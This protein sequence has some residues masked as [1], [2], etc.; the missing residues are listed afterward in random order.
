[1]VNPLFPAWVVSIFS[2]T[3]YDDY[4]APAFNPPPTLSPTANPTEFPT[5][6]PTT[7]LFALNAPL[8]MS[9]DITQ[10]RASVFYDSYGKPQITVPYVASNRAYE[11]LLF[12]RDCVTPSIVPSLK[13]TQERSDKLGFIDV[14]AV[15]TVYNVAD[16][17]TSNLWGVD[18]RGAHFKFCLDYRMFASNKEYAVK[19]AKKIFRV[20][21][22]IVGVVG[23]GKQGIRGEKQ[24]R[25]SLDTGV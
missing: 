24:Y 8:D 20:N 1:M 25:Y 16:I 7:E 6:K 10:K 17:Q 11:I 12:E 23:F 21:V 13:H 4:V 14:T 18:D 3:F 9:W 2:G 19:S 5:T 15:L 22:G